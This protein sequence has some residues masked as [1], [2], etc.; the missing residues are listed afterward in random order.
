MFI[1][2]INARKGKIYILKSSFKKYIYKLENI[3]FLNNSIFL[4]NK[5]KLLE[6]LSKNIGKNV[7]F[8]RNIFI[9]TKTSFENL[10]IILTKIISYCKMLDCKKI[11]L[12]KK[13]FWFISNKIN[14]KNNKY[15]FNIRVDNKL[16][17]QD[18]N[19]IIDNTLN[20]IFY[21][22]YNNPQN[23]INILKKEILKNLPKVYINPKELFIYIKSGDIFINYNSLYYI[24]PPL[25]FYQKILYNYYY[26]FSNVTII[27]EDN[28]NIIINK[29]IYEFPNITFKIISSKYNI[30]YLSK[31]YNI[32]GG[33]CNL[34]YFIIRLNNN[35]NNI[36]EFETQYFINNENLNIEKA[37]QFSNSKKIILYKM[38]ASK[39]YQKIMLDKENTFNKL[40]LMLN[41]G[42]K[43]NF[44]INQY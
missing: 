39:N 31:A 12:D 21:F 23:E 17:I 36:W 5:E 14:I 32:V 8:V 38:V 34:L 26:N 6:I 15:G 37:I 42:C 29:I 10:L 1:Y 22:N 19:I 44:T 13:N 35:L 11:I 33:N 24:Q 27:S 30:A 40:Y 28:K 43:N 7:T 18:L 4:N 20:T 25:C 41:F 16:N 3:H 9:G 2:Y